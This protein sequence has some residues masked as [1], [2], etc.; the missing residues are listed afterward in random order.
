MNNQPTM[1]EHELMASRARELARPLAST[2]ILDAPTSQFVSV[3]LE[4]ETYAFPARYVL[5]AS[6]AL[7]VVTMPGA[8]APLAGVTVYE[9]DILP[10]FYL[11]HLVGMP[12]QRDT[13]TMW[14]LVLGERA[15]EIG[16]LV[17]R[18]STV[19]ALDTSELH[20]GWI[21]ATSS[22]SGLLTATTPDG[23][24]IVDVEHLLRD[25]RLVIDTGNGPQR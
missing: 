7:A 17:D 3:L 25:E 5:C 19:A 6:N 1:K 12:T 22:A 21:E 11:R 18:V 14:F 24:T 8:Q 16:L 13:A 15:A 10:V 4:E 23:V 20:P 9:G 2:R